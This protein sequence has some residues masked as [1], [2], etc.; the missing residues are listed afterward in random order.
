MGFLNVAVDVCV[1]R[2]AN[3]TRVGIED[4]AGTKSDGV[5]AFWYGVVVRAYWPR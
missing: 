3:S 2:S 1:T 4:A 5:W